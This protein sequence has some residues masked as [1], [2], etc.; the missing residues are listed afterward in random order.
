M[1]RI[2]LIAIYLALIFITIQLFLAQKYISYYNRG[3]KLYQ[4][5]RYEEAIEEYQK[6]LDT[7]VPKL[8]E[9]NIR[10]NYA[11]AICK[12]VEVN[13]SD[14]ES[15]REAIDKYEQ[16]IDVLT[17]QG[18]ANKDDDNGHNQNAE[19]LK[20]EIQKEIDRLKKL[21]KNESSDEENE[22]NNTEEEQI[23]EEQ[24]QDLK[25]EAIRKQR[26]MENE[27]RAINEDYS[28]V[29]KNW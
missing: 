5:T 27:H 17:E 16:A 24:I 14:E 18:C 12:T 13:E 2:V 19:T 8:K 21:L 1:K 25:E 29:E 9:C 28:R 20:K 3:N 7:Y 15:I 22:K 4:E 10:I 11:L 26:E 23:D 6:A